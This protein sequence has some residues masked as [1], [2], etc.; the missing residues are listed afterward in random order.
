MPLQPSTKVRGAMFGV[1]KPVFDQFV[2][3]EPPRRKKF[4][5]SGVTR[6]VGVVI[7]LVSGDT[8]ARCAAQQRASHTAA[9]G[10][11]TCNVQFETKGTS[12]RILSS[13][14]T[15][16]TLEQLGDFLE[17]VEFLDNEEIAAAAAMQ[18][19]RSGR[20]LNYCVPF[21]EWKTRCT[22]QSG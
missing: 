7:P 9:V 3:M 17:S 12:K 8:P 1:M 20:N 10:C 2:D 13:D 15:P 4:D 19:V 16:G 6:E 5:V 14:K 21:S 18:F 22:Q 11:G